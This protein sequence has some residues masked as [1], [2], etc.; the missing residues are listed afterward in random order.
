MARSHPA[1]SRL[2]LL[3]L[4]ALLPL[5]GACS[6]SDDGCPRDAQAGFEA[7]APFDT[8]ARVRRVDCGFR[9]G[10]VKLAL[11]GD[12]SAW[13]RRVEFKD[14]GDDTFF[15]PP[16]KLLTHLGPGGE[17]LGELTTPDFV[18][19]FV[20][21]PSG[22]LTVFGWD[23]QADAL[24]MQVRR[25]RPDGSLISERL[26][27]ND[28]PPEER[29]NYRATPDGRVQKVDVPENE[30]GF[31]VLAAEP[32][33]EDV[34]V[35]LGMD[36]LR[37]LR[38]GSTLETRWARVVDASVFL[39]A[40]DASGMRALGAPF[41]G[42]GL[43][44][45]EAGRAHV[46]TSFL[47]VERTAYVQAFGRFPEGPTG[48][49]ILLSAFE[50]TG[51]PVGA[52]TVPTDTADEIAGLVAGH[53]AFALTA[54]ASLP[55]IEADKPTDTDLFF[56]SGR[57]DR[58]AEESVTRTFSLDQDEAP[59]ALVACGEG[60]YCLAGHTSYVDLESGRTPDNG[61]GFVLTVDA[62][63]AQQDLLLLEGERDTEVL[64]AVAGPG[65][66][67]V[68]VFATNQPVNIARVANHLKH[69]EVWLGV[70]GGP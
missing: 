68:F 51:T 65:G 17:F 53:G 26:L 37:L 11:A 18:Q 2:R 7:R 14:R 70:Y 4:A 23:K 19:D 61:Q 58:P 5:L 54:R 57:W 48:R 24:T 8:R 31:G 39:T 22:E 46:A 41:T 45:D 42:V 6:D 27:R 25:L 64:D 12:G 66:S 40:A 55:T 34:Y 36:G 67:V 60:R 52:R 1:T 35:L 21:H 32:H 43:A 3:V 20:V 10:V 28:V 50:P 56:A 29:L 69:N 13:L 33:G 63:G 47:K 49:S 30:R 44:V 15:H 9:S 62:S 16:D 59:S 38:L